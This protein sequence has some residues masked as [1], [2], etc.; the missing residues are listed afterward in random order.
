MAVDPPL[1]VVAPGASDA[2]LAAIIVA[3]QQLWPEPAEPTVPS[4]PSPWRFSGRWWV[5]SGQ[6]KRTGR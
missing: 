4:A 1:H 2:E 6:P 3:Y 5:D